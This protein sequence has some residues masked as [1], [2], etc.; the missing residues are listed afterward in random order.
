[1]LDAEAVTAE[2]TSHLITYQETVDSSRRVEA[3]CKVVYNCA[4]PCT[5]AALHARFVS[6]HI[7]RGNVSPGHLS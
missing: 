2:L 5:P 7:A 6:I 1:M 4:H 3:Q